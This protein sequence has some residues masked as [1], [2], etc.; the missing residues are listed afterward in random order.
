MAW[1]DVLIDIPAAVT[2]L[3]AGDLVDVVP[4]STSSI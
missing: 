2:E 4:L 3:G 1:A